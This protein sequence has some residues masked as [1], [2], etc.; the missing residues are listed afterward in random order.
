MP[1]QTYS[2]RGQRT[3]TQYSFSVFHCVQVEGDE[4]K[5]D[6]SYGPLAPSFKTLWLR[7]S[8]IE[9]VGLRLNHSSR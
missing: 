5:R 6:F 8:L 3:P 1:I 2:T 9:L 7:M 4:M